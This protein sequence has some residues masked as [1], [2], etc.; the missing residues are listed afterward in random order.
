MPNISESQN[1]TDG[2]SSSFQ[3]TKP[4]ISN[5]FNL[6][7]S[8][9]K[10]NETFEKEFFQTSGKIQHFLNPKLKSYSNI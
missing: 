6:T 10:T 7:F 3:L 5:E 2:S 9:T 1:K 4:S 8:K